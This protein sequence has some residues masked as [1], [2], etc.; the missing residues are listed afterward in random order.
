VGKFLFLAA[1]GT[2]GEAARERHCQPQLQPGIKRSFQKRSSER[3]G[4]VDA[5]ARAA[6]AAVALA[7]PALEDV[8]CKGGTW[9]GRPF[10]SF[11]SYSLRVEAAGAMSR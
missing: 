10:G 3:A 8:R 9:A 6:I 1:Y 2:G 11:F 5:T 7:E 4:D